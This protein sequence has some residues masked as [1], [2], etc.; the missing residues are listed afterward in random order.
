MTLSDVAEELE[1]SPAKLGHIETGIRKW[2]SVTEVAELLRLYGVTGGQREAILTLVRESRMRPWWTEYDDVVSP[3]YVGNEAGAVAIHTYP[4]ILVP[5]LL[6][7]P[8][9]TA[10]MAR[11]QGRGVR[12]AERVVAAYLK[13]Q[14]LLDRENLAIYHA[15]IEEDALRR[16]SS[17]GTLLYWQLQ[18]LISMAEAD[19]AVSIQMIPS[20]VGP[21]PGYAGPFTILEFD[22]DESALVYVE[23][24]QG[25]GI[26]EDTRA[27]ERCK[28]VWSDLTRVAS[29]SESTMTA[30]K[31]LALL[32]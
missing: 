17:Q 11:S 6:Q 25:G 7:V 31:R 18:H 12:S 13:R 28:Q 21:H 5:D 24:P 23:A 30:L 27:V 32:A 19:N 15:I 3:A 9:Y 26:V 29:G 22:E 4:G 1:W 14:E 8:D 10:L 2:P 16:I 20:T